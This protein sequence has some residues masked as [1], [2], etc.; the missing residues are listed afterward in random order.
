VE[1]KKYSDL[2][3]EN[4]EK[5]W[6]ANPRNLIAFFIFGLINNFSYVLF[7][8]AAEDILKQNKLPVGTGVILLCNIGPGMI[9]QAL[10]PFFMEKIP[11][12]L[13]I[14]FL[15]LLSSSSFIIIFFAT[16]W[17]LSLGAIVLAS[18]ASCIGEITFMALSSYYNKNTVSSYSS[19]TGGAGVFGSL[20]YLLLR[21]V[22]EIDPKI[23][24]LISG[25]IPLTMIIS[26]FFI[27]EDSTKEIQLF[28]DEKVPQQE[29][30]SLTASEKL[31]LQRKL[32]KYSGPLFLVYVSEYM[33]NQAIIPVETFPGTYFYGK[34]YV[35]YQFLYQFG[36]AVSRSSVSL[37]QI[38][39]LWFLSYL[40]YI[41]CCFL[42]IAVY[43]NFIPS[44]WIVFVIILYEGLIGGGVYVNAFYLLAEEIDENIKEYCMGAVS[45][46]Y[47]CGI[48]ISALT[49]LPV[50]SWLL[51]NRKY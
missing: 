39:Q 49:G 4:V 13:R 28:V 41:N 32:F 46:W 37:F 20:F 8:S 18:I 30:I 29:K 16:H 38:K 9:G 27:L 21:A 19:G 14:S 15:A 34:E 17:A 6:V 1:R 23:I 40:Q 7:L 12:W 50:N 25:P 44:I 26:Y 11:F 33:I 3:D 31:N 43:L 42:L 2:T 22:F 35:I 47:S 48:L 51:K 5:G 24:L 10:A 45:F 36:V